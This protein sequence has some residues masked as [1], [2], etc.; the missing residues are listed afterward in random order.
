MTE[1]NRAAENFNHVRKDYNMS[2]KEAAVKT[3]VIGISWI[4]MYLAP[5]DE[6]HPEHKQIFEDLISAHEKP[7]DG[8]DDTK[9]F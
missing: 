2:C 5:D 3:M 6:N 9:I 1:L 8:E 7:K 4:G